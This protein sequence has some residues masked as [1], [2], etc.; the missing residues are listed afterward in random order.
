MNDQCVGY[1]TMKHTHTLYHLTTGH[2]NRTT[3]PVCDRSQQFPSVSPEVSGW[4]TFRGGDGSRRWLVSTGTVLEKVGNQLFTGS[5][6]RT[7]YER[8]D[9]IRGIPGSPR[10]S[11]WIRC[12][13]IVYKT[14]GRE[15][16][17][18]RTE[19]LAQKLNNIKQTLDRNL[20]DSFHCRVF[21]SQ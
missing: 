10:G 7:M 20:S 16:V 18:I 19:S 6:S 8:N 3:V 17:E 2:P 13:R 21:I 5:R 12:C 1:E 11:H 9:G 15:P 14:Y 4:Y